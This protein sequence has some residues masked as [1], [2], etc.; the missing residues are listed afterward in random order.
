MEY[1]EIPPVA[2]NDNSTGNVPGAAV[3]INVLS[4]DDLS[5]GSNVTPVR[6]SVDLDPST[7]GI[8]NSLTVAG[9]GAWIY[10]TATGEVTF[11]PQAGYTTDPTNISY[12]LTELLTG[13]SD[14][15]A[16]HVEYTEIPPVAVN[17]NSTGNVPGAAVTLNVLS[18]DDLSDGS[19]VTPLR[20]SV[21][22][23]PS[24]AGI[25]NSLTVAGQGAWT[26]NSGTGE[27]TFT[28][29]AGYT[30]DPTNISYVLTELLTGLSD[31]AAIHVEYTEVPPVAVND[32][33]T[34]N[35]PGAAVTINVLSNDDLS[36][37]SNV[38]PLRVS[39]DLDPVDRG[40]TK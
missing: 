22:L 4:N 19:N 36:D 11:T 8:Q 39:V 18:N 9:Q 23:D 12:V 32:N 33:S 10:N 16:I 27:V 25:Q 28:P 31:T 14:T 29:Q 15:A 20:V 37:G 24:T 30:T 3:T 6:V 35:V 13:L 17:D 26:Y 2:V 1:T 5:D 21:D 7:A 38:T 40:H 34:G